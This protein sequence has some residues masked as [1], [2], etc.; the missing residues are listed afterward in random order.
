MRELLGALLEAQKKIKALKKD[1]VNPYY[2]SGYVS[3]NAVREAVLP[4]L[5]ENGLVLLQP[6]EIENGQLV[7]KTRLIHTETGQ[8]I[9]STIPVVTADFSDAQKVG[10]GISYA[11]RYAIQSLLFLSAED[12]DGNSAVNKTALNL[13]DEGGI[14]TKKPTFN[15]QK[16]Q[17][18]EL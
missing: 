15:K 18:E 6:T 7:V 12:D 3:L 17:K 2:K 8:E 1:E 14:V 11:R 10:S 13:T 5:Q 4:A 9:T 16:I